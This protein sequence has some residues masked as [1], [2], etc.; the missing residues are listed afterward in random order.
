VYWA[1]APSLLF[2]PYLLFNP[3]V[4][5]ALV[6]SC[7]FVHTSIATAAAKFYGELR[8]MVYTTPKSY[9]DLIGLYTNKLGA[10]QAAV[11]LKRERM[12]VGVA[13]LVETEGI[14]DSLKNDLTKLAPILI[15][16]SKDA[17]ELLVRRFL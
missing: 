13:K 2:L 14:V 5:D 12:V 1:P 8:R 11:D 17:D 15:Q 9:L 6:R 7:G 16:K 4:R 3:Q 10:L